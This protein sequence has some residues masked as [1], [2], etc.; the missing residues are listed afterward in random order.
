MSS[1][2][3]FD[4]QVLRAMSILLELAEDLVENLEYWRIGSSIIGWHNFEHF[5]LVRALSI[6]WEVDLTGYGFTSDPKEST[7]PCCQKVQKLS[8]VVHTWQKLPVQTQLKY[9][10][11]IGSHRLKTTKSC[12]SG[13]NFKTHGRHCS[14]F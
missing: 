1:L 8:T 10:Y 13:P 9:V 2:L 12:H 11:T 6:M 7:L 3:S 14:S 5:E 4:L